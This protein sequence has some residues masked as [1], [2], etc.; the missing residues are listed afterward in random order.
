MPTYRQAEF[1]PRALRSLAEQSFT[2]WELVVVNDGSPDDTERIIR[3]F[4][5]RR[6]T[7]VSFEE[8]RGLGAALNAATEHAEGRYISYLPSD[9][10]Y[11][12]DHLTTCVEL[13]EARDEIHLAYGGVRWHPRVRVSAIV[14]EESPTLRPDVL[15]GFEAA[16]LDVSAPPVGGHAVPSGNF[17]APVQVVQRRTEAL[18]T[19]W[20]ERS[21]IVSDS[22]EFDYWRELLAR[23]CRFAYTGR[24]TCEWGDHPHQHHKI[25]SGRGADNSDWRNHSYGLSHYKQFYQVP[26]GTRLNWRPVVSGSPVDERKRYAGL[27]HRP[28]SPSPER[29]LKILLVGALSFNPDRLLALEER[30]HRLYGLWM[31]RPHFWDTAGP[32]AFGNVQ[33]VPY[34]QHVKD[35]I[36]EIAPDVV[37]ALLNWNALPFIHEVFTRRPSVPFVFHFKESPFAAI[38]AGY[39]S[40]LRE[41]VL[42]S[43]GRIFSSEEERDW[44]SI[45]LGTDLSDCRTLVLD[46]DLPKADWMTDA[47]SPRL[48]DADGEPHTVC[49]GR[50][51]LEPLAEIVDRGVNV[52]LYTQPYMRYGK[53]WNIVAAAQELP[54]VHVH[55]P[56]M[57]GE[58]VRELSR[59]DAAWLHSFSS[60]NNGDMQMADWNDL[61]LP[62]RLATYGLA[63]LPWLMRDNTGHRVAVHSIAEKLG[64]AIP[65]G[66]Y[67]ELAAGLRHECALREA[68]S[69][70]RASRHEFTFDDHVDELIRFMT[71]V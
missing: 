9:D 58:W 1:L 54:R 35:R 30:G 17:L 26:R 65:Y 43:E 10:V 40:A 70:M 39:W 15:P 20:N 11:A 47:W 6:L 21:E 61:N 64:V 66:D 41:L 13:L 24:V 46:G 69:A 55:P 31:P 22:L 68:S 60:Q 4:D 27:A 45:A 14:P 56:V 44:F 62:A 34:D 33:D 50:T 48:S 57:P 23:G 51:F 3:E 49:V 38:R 63:G 25:I 29:G 42:E 71:S 7:Y 37:Y 36:D 5:C 53:D 52:H 8:N 32:L 19:R 16:A 67:D 28:L 59:Y 18:A 12:P 2:D